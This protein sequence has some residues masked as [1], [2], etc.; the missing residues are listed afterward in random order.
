[1]NSLFYVIL[2]VFSYVILGFVIKKYFNISNKII[3]KFDYLSFN[4]L[5]PIALITYF[6]Q[7]NFPSFNTLSLLFAFFGAGIFVF[8]IGYQIAYYKFKFT[9]DDSALIGLASCFGNSVALGIPLMHTLFGKLNVMP[10]MILVLF[11]GL[12]HFTYTTLLIES[13]RN[14]SLKIHMQILSSL[15]GLFKNAVLVGIFFGISLNYFKIP[16]PTNLLNI[17]NI[18]SEIALPC[19]LLSLGFALA[20]FNLILSLKKSAILTFLKNILHPLIAFTISKFFLNLDELLVMTVTLAAAL[21]SGS[22]TYY[23]AFRYN[24][25]KE[26]VSSNIVLSTFV[27]FFTLSILIIL[28]GF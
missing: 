9:V 26:L 7:I 13:Y 1:M 6:W 15:I 10:Y 14:R 17:L 21:P 11:H 24:S 22:Q 12:V 2:S 16:Q 3:N 28:F 5:L 23:F 4:I 18:I 8:F 27:S 19:V 20:T 25:Q